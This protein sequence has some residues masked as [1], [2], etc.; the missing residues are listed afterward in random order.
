MQHSGFRH[1]LVFAALVLA[2]GCRSGPIQ[3]SNSTNGA[4]ET[5]LAPFG[6]GFAV[7]WYDQRDGNAEI[8]L[9]LLNADGQA[10]GPER[11]LTRSSEDSWEASIDQF[12]D[13]IAIAWYEQSS[14]GMQTAKLGLWSRDG[15]NRWMHSFRGGTRNPVVHA[16]AKSIFC[17]WVQAEADGHE[18][19]FAGWWDGSGKPLSAAIRLGPASKTTWNLNAA[20]DGSGIGWVVY[21]AEVE[22]RASEVYIARADGIASGAVRLTN[23]DNAP[24]KYPDLAIGAA[25]RAALSW[26]DERDGNVEVYLITGSLTDLTGEIDAR[27]RRV[28]NT[29]GESSGAYLSWNGDRLG[30]AWSDKM[31]GQHDVHFAS[32]D[33][34]GMMREPERRITNTSAWS[35]V[36]AI[37]PDGAGFALSWIEYVPPSVEVNEGTSQ[38]FFQKI[39]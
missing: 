16:N 31:S 38:V 23:D 20:I 35:L 9:R 37:R 1:G 39:S 14:T 3:V 2:S 32:F 18:A 7:A 36:R 30:L 4:Y 24:S 26:Q 13:S 22:T 5:A 8:Y 28:T 11:R 12:A 34:N 21:D 25:G 10:A 33:A 27:S 17:A 29:P 15:A 6:D 19:V